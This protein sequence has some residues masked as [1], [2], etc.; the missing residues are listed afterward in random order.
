MKTKL[1]W[2]SALALGLMT[3]ALVSPT[4]SAAQDTGYVHGYKDR[5]SSLV[6]SKPNSQPWNWNWHAYQWYGPPQSYTLGYQ[7][8]YVWTGLGYVPY[9]FQGL[10]GVAYPIVYRGGPR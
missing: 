8:V 2:T 10:P 6:K 1:K 4:Y 5:S 3:V 9:T 7:I